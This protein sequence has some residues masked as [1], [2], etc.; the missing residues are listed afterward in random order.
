MSKKI[1]ITYF[2]HG[3]ENLIDDEL[4]DLGDQ[5]NTMLASKELQKQLIAKGALAPCFEI[6]PLFDYPKSYDET[7]ARSHEEHAAGA[8]PLIVE[9]P[10]NFDDFDIVF[11]GYPNWWGTCPTPVMTFLDNHN[12]KGKIVIP[13]VTHGGQI[14]M[15]SIEE[16]KQEIP[17]ATIKEGFAIA[18]AYISSCSKVISNYLEKNSDLFN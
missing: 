9:G 18:A 16:I 11:V 10:D 4:V 2:S 7:V 13:F 1:L 6:K 12:F 15:Y 14:F 3:G 17:A 8:R 5:G